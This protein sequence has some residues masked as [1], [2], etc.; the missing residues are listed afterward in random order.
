[1]GLGQKLGQL[2][3]LDVFELDLHLLRLLLHLCV[4]AKR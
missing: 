1:M 2:L 3:G 4:F